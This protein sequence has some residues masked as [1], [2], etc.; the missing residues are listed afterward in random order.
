MKAISLLLSI[1]VVVLFLSSCQPNQ[2]K[3]TISHS[4]TDSISPTNIWSMWL[5]KIEML[6]GDPLLMVSWHNSDTTIR[7]WIYCRSWDTLIPTE[8]SQLEIW[9]KKD[10]LRVY[11]SNYSDHFPSFSHR[12]S[13][14]DTS[15]IAGLDMYD[16]LGSL[17]ALYLK[18]NKKA[19]DSLLTTVFCRER[20]KKE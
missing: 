16:S 20:R 3:N 13:D 19:Y 12:L 4:T 5:E 7:Y 10:S 11:F 8:L 2:G 17:N 6:P 9:N 1:V 18:E 15:K 14:I